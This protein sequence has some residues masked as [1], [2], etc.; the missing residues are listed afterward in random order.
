M[1]KRPVPGKDHSLGPF[2]E[3]FQTGVPIFMYHK[4]GRR[5]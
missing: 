2:R 4:V 1:V 5:P 3:F